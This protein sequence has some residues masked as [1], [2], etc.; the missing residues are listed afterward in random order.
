MKSFKEY[1]YG[2][3]QADIESLLA[4]A[5]SRRESENEMLSG[6]QLL[7]DVESY[8]AVYAQAGQETRLVIDDG[9]P[10]SVIVL[11]KRPDKSALLTLTGPVSDQFGDFSGVTAQLV[12]LSKEDT[13]SLHME[14]TSPGGYLDVGLGVA[15][16][17]RTVAN[18]GIPVSAHMLG[19][20]GSASTLIY[21]SADD[22]S[23]SPGTAFMTHKPLRP[24]FL[25]LGLTEDNM[26]E[27]IKDQKLA[28][29]ELTA[30]TSATVSFMA[31]RLKAPEAKIREKL[32]EEKYWTEEELRESG[33][34]NAKAP[35]A[36][37]PQPAGKSDADNQAR[38]DL[39]MAANR[40]RLRFR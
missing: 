32:A 14:I 12:R 35:T 10:E 24:I 34:V 2:D 3:P 11:E 30:M 4:Q 7:R 9:R 1:W 21:L 27:L 18:K 38:R 6:L 8:N 40:A 37:S 29:A 22:R 31:D 25:F 15:Q 16:A 19:V 33:I 17:V 23:S 26:D 28:E 5:R 36:P 13:T 39:L 20:V